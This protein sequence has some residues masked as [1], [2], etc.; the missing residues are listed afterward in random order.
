MKIKM[1]Q[2]YSDKPG[3]PQLGDT[4]EVVQEIY[5]GSRFESYVC[6]WNG[7]DIEVYPY[8]CEELPK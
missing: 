2:N 5:D 1:T 3:D 6:E 7:K 8:E 4:L